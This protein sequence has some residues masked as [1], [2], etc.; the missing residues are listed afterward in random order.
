M[1]PP[2]AL[3]PPPTANTTKC[4]NCGAEVHSV[5]AQRRITELEA[6]V[7]ILSEKATNA[8]DKLADYE[9]EL[10][11]LRST[12][13]SSSSSSSSSLTSNAPS[14][15]TSATNRISAFL[16]ASPRGRGGGPPSP[17]P[18]SN[19]TEV[20]LEKERKARVKAEERLE[21]VT[22]ELEEL[23]ASL[24]QSANEMVADERRQRSKLEERV[25]MLEGRDEEVRKRLGVLES[26]M[27]RIVRVRQVLSVS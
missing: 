15:I 26:A 2:T 5:E 11:A 16:T 22:G 6:Q 19:S 8:V 23:S 10:K 4:Q 12:P 13:P 24:F 25:R 7:R 9:D 14:G 20:L 17:P 21:Q 3:S 18:D 27:D 1:S